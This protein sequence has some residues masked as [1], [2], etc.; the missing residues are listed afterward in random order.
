MRIVAWVLIGLVVC[1][2]GLTG[3]TLYTR[4]LKVKFQ[5]AEVIPAEEREAEFRALSDDV[6]NESV[7]GVV[8]SAEALGAPTDYEFHVYT[9]EIRNNCF[10]GAEWVRLEVEPR[11]GDILLA[12]KEGAPELPSMSAGLIQA[13]VLARKDSELPRQLKLTYF[14][15]GSSFSIPITAQ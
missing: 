11:E 6:A 1:F 10:F 13:T 15:L 5:Q 9:V 2:A 14:L 3:Y 8:Y 7:R 4:E 12:E